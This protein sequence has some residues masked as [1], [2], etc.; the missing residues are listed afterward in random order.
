MDIK[1][2]KKEKIVISGNLKRFL[3]DQYSLELGEYISFEILEFILK[4]LKPYF[5]QL[6]KEKL[7]TLLKNIE[8]EIYS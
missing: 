7:E 1:I 4:E 6:N 8:K 3:A 2:N 5:N